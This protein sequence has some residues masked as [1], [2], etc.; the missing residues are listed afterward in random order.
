MDT[1]LRLIVIG[2]L[3]LISLVIIARG[4]RAVSIPLTL[5]KASVAAFLIKTS[6]ALSA[7]V[8][9]ASAP[10]IMLSW[11]GPYLVWYCAYAI[12]GF[13][14][15]PVWVMVAFP[16]ATVV[17]CGY[18]MLSVH[19]P[20]TV[21]YASLLTSLVAVLHALGSVVRGSLDDLSGPRRQFRLCFVG[22]ITSVSII[23]LVLELLFL[24]TQPDWL[25][26]ALASVVAVG[27]LLVG[28][29]LLARPTDLLP[30]DVPP[31]N[32]DRLDR[33][34]QAMHDSLVRAMEDR[35]YA[36]TGLTIRSLAEELELPEHQLRK[37]INTRLGYKNFSTFLNGYRIQETLDRLADPKKARVP[38]LTIALD[39]GFASLAPFNRAFRA[40]TGM[41][42]SEYRREQ[43]KPADVVTVLH[44]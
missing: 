31:D 22:C 44:G 1:A 41:T 32:D 37:L 24:S 21:R 36:R 12:F 35:A 19:A 23:I 5:L 33:G 20:A 14:R 38:I 30:D 34:E 17:L 43:L 11:A 6:P 9:F 39:A 16:T 13:E 8:P 18:D 15:P 27:V 29:P 25:P 10:I 2:Q 7:A 40:S 42:P 26:T 28:V 3:V 4:P